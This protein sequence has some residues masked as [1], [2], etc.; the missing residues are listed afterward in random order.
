MKIAHST[1]LIMVVPS[2]HKPHQSWV[3]GCCM[4]QCSRSALHAASSHA[5]QAYPTVL[6]LDMTKER[7][8]K[9]LSNVELSISSYDTA[10]V[11]MV[12]SPNSPNSPC[13][14]ECLNWVMDNQLND[15]SWG[16]HHHHHPPL[17]KD[18]LSSTLASV[19]A[20]KRWNVGE[21]QINKGLCF[22]ESNF[23]S[24][25]DKNQPSP[26]GFDIIFP[27]MLE[28]A[29]DSNI[30]LPLNE[31]DLSVML[32]QRELEIRRCHSYKKD[33]Y[34]AYISEGLGN[35]HDWN[36]VMK[37]QMK[38]GSL[39]NS[40]SATAAALIHHRDAGCLNYLTSLLEKFG[41]AVPTIY[42]LDLYVRL[43]MVDTLEKLGI[44][45]HFRVEIQNVL[46]E[47][48]RCWVQRDE[49]IFMDVV[50]SALAFRVLRTNGYEVSSDLL[51]D[52]TKEGDYMNSLEEP[53]KDVY[54]A[55]EV[56]RASQ[57]IHQEELAFGE[58]NLRSIDF[59]K[60]KISTAS[61]PSNRHSKFIHKEV[62][63]ALKFPS[64][65]S[66]ERMSTRR[67]IEH[68]NVDDTRILK[69]TYR[70]LNISNEDYLTL[71][72]EDFNAC[73]SIYREEIKGL[74]RWVVENRLDKLKFARQKTAYC[75]F[76]AASTLSSPELSDARISW[77]KNGILTTVVDD[78]FD[79]G[80]S[81][82][83]LWL[84]LMKSM[85]REAIW[86]KEDRVPTITE[87]ME[88]GYVSFALGPIV[89]PALYFIGPRLSE[90]IV[91]SS[92]Y[93]NLFKL[94]STQGRLLNDIQG[95]KREM[96]A[97]KLNALSLHMIHG[98]NGVPEEG[99]VEEMKMVISN[100]RREL[101]RLVLQTK[102]SIVPKA[103]K[104]AF[105]NMSNVL[106]LFY[107]T[108]DGFTGN[109]ILDTVKQTI[110]EPVSPMETKE[111]W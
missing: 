80:G 21:D 3:V 95:F 93:H 42:P 20:L 12:P 67:N 8:K 22:I 103:C 5:G 14:P 52:I 26:V 19:L 15:G 68:Y 107:A 65:A 49:Q 86:S 75:Y 38:S 62:E 11:A 50:T 16:L 96:K 72:V 78:F 41:N 55:L 34:L 6:T 77:A 70:S 84:D 31:T 13:F 85:L 56:Y 54:A 102:G 97:G 81:M 36:M 37:Y 23:A 7:I 10:W 92:E 87:Y 91:Q 44:S 61:S 69:T 108:D 83:E 58:R 29:K 46:D 110:Y 71:A 4:E 64:N 63:N 9:L 105:W 76:S 89:L 47:T 39:F 24:A 59:L 2:L 90:E 101:M 17:L 88:N 74:E 104:D 100:Q 28:Y 33:A 57:I 43:H 25:T 18:S 111:H 109:A 30:R 73:Q 94:M 82:D 60:R 40:P 1:S 27:G 51:A 35:F 53:F 32:H 66:L 106:N 99:V 45:R 98:K 79:V 48:Y